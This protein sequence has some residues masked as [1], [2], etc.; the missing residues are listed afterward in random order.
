MTDE[1]PAEDARPRAAQSPAQ[2]PRDRQLRIGANL[3][4]LAY[5]ELVSRLQKQEGGISAMSVDQL[6]QLMGLGARIEAT[7]LMELPDDGND[8]AQDLE[9]VLT[10]LGL[11]PTD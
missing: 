8:L 6:A 7:A 5:N 1:A 9:R 2:S 10:E 4:S 3:S 11:E